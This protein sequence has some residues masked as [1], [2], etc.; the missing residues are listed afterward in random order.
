MFGKW[1]LYSG[2]GTWHFD[3]L[4]DAIAKARSLKG[5]DT[6]TTIKDSTGMRVSF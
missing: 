4:R 5:C 6:W 3:E 1:T 2:M